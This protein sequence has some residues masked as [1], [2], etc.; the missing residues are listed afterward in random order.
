MDEQP[1]PEEI[2]YRS[3]PTCDL[4]TWTATSIAIRS[5]TNYLFSKAKKS[6]TTKIKD[7][8]TVNITKPERWQGKWTSFPTKT[9]RNLS[10]KIV[11]SKN[12]KI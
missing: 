3:K 6:K 4:W 11:K 5:H 10:N 8:Y 9:I 7:E 1:G 12:P 2:A